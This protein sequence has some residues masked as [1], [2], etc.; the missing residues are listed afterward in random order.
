MTILAH[1][2]LWTEIHIICLVLQNFLRVLWKAVTLFISAFSRNFALQLRN[3]K[4]DLCPLPHPAHIPQKNKQ[5][6]K[7]LF[8]YKSSHT[9]V[10][11]GVD[12]VKKVL[13]QALFIF[14]QHQFCSKIWYNIFMFKETRLNDGV[15]CKLP[16]VKNDEIPDCR[17]MSFI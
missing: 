17:E 1:L 15:E 16:S 3:P 5:K 10:T 14:L 11:D 2:S 7:T 6:P 13:G 9:R 8:A 4:Q 12:G